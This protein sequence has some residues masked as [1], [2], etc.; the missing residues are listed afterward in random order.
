MTYQRIQYFLK[1]AETGSLKKAAE[2]MYVS[3]QALTKQVGFLEEELGGKLFE[4]SA[5]GVRLT[6]LGEAA[7][8]KLGKLDK[9]LQYELEELKRLARGGK[10][11]LRIGIFSALPQ[12]TMITPLVSFLLTAFPQYQIGLELIG[13]DEGRKLLMDGELDIFL[14][15]THDEDDWGTYRCLSFGEYRTKVIVSLNH[16][17]AVKD[18]ITLEDLKQ[19]TFL[20][21]KMENSR[22]KI[23]LEDSFYG[24]IP[25]KK[26]QYVVNFDTMYALLQQGEAFAVF[27]MAFLY[28]DVARIKAFD[29]PGKEL[30]YHSVLVYNPESILPGFAD[31]IQ[32]IQEEF[33]LKRL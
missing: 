13:L 26:I 17:W 24:Q 25:C 22:Y 7:Q 15:N 20:K 33:D 1:A 11:R 3:A 19:G 5:K 21:M 28:M 14:T 32:E 23:P 27:P 12:D 2:Q 9:E 31:M 30:I 4:R 29:Y 16:P 18:R 8:Q 10:E 6:W